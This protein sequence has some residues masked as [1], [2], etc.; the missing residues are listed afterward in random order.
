M[1]GIVG[2]VG[3]RPSQDILLAGLAR[4]EYRGYDSAG[5]A[6][7]DGDGVLGMRKKAGKLAVLR[8]SLADA[9]LPDGSTGIGHTRWATHGGPTDGNA[10][11]HLADDDKLAVIHNGIIENFSALRD[12]LL[13]DGVV[14]RSETDT[15]VAA[16]L[17]GREYAGNGGDLQLAFR[18]IVNRLEGAFTLLAMHQDHPGLVVGARRNSPLVIGLGEGE[19]FLGSDVA[20]FIEYT[21]KALAIG[22]DQ[23][24]SI[25]PESVTVMD[26][27]GTPVEPEPF[28]VSWDAAA[29]E[30]GGWSSF[31]AKEVA[32]QPEA[33][34][35][36]IRG[37]IHDGQVV[38]PE[39]DG[40][41]E[42][43]VGINRV[44][45]TACGT[46]SYAALVGKYAIEQWAR[47]AVDVE[48]AHEFRYRDPVIGADTLVV[49]ISQSGETMDT[50]MAVKYARERGARTLSVCN[51]QGATIP[52]ESDAVV[53]THAGPEVAVASTKAFSAQIT[54][55]L[56]LGLHMGRVRGAIADASVD[57]AELA[58]LPEKI[59]KVLE[60]EQEHVTQLA[61]W[62]A[63]TR[64][65]LFLGRHVGYPIALEGALKLKEISYIHA[66]GFAAGELKHGPIALIEPGQPVFV[67]VPSPR[68]SAL[69]H[70]KV[71]SNIQEIRARGA[72]VIVIA[73]EGDAAVLPFADEVI[74][75]PLAGAMFE[76]LLAVVPLQ[77]FAMALAT[78]K[79]LD[80][81]QP[82]NLA[83]S[84]TVE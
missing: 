3:P 12:E 54:A 32:E 47:V 74:H 11:P 28:D 53:Y 60:S 66:E 43:F 65:V 36:T 57:V 58:A 31:M 59:A 20:A 40:L 45:I 49:S 55:L 80:V 8:D 5:V 42:L 62:M 14:F 48:L 56:L 52:R 63:D 81:D 25:T 35:N 69:V 70:S 29:A 13:A 18:S 51:T 82:R 39:L 73:E 15:E 77:I 17:L 83:K 50:L 72:R 19:N 6:V 34:A 67:L 41:D 10:H 84:V 16:A 46:A 24:V 37:R 2:Y 38:I 26:F 9:P 27:A 76:P 75:I 71:V 64:S 79:G 4:L 1:C 23:I 22:Q 78:A 68:H 30:K 21:R 7:I 61:G 33:V 44:I